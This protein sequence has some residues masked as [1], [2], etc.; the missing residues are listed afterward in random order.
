VPSPSAAPSAEPGATA[1]PTPAPSGDG[2]ESD[3]SGNLVMTYALFIGA[4]IVVVG[5]VLAF[6]FRRR[7]ARAAGEKDE[8]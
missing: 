8:E 2:G 1:A 5:I 7:S 6:I 4:I 3:D